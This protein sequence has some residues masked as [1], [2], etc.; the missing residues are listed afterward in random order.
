MWMEGMQNIIQSDP[1]ILDSK[2]IF[3]FDLCI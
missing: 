3:C 1:K 2:L